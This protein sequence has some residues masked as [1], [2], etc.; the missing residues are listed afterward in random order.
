MRRLEAGKVPCLKAF[1]ALLYCKLRCLAF[2][3]RFVSIHRDRTFACFFTSS[4][5]RRLEFA[6]GRDTEIALFLLVRILVCYGRANTSDLPS[7][8]TASLPQKRPQR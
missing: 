1:R 5:S 4:T 7:T 3:E 8:M 2:V 6:G